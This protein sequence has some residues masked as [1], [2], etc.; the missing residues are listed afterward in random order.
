LDL[1]SLKYNFPLAVNITKFYC[2][3]TTFLQLLKSEIERKP[4]LD[5]EQFD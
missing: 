3:L 5:F 1:S 4:H 2:S